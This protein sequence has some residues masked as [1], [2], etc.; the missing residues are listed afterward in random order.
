MPENGTGVDSLSNA[1]YNDR[2]IAFAPAL[3]RVKKLL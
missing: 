2:C 1:M 3:Q